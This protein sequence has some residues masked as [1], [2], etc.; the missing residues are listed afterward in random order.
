MTEAATSNTE[1]ELETY[2][3]QQKTHPNT[4]STTSDSALREDELDAEN[5][6]LRQSGTGFIGC[7][8]RIPLPIKLIILVALST[9]GVILLT[10]GL[11][12]IEGDILT[13]AT[14]TNTYI[15]NILPLDSF[16]KCIRAE[17]EASTIYIS[18]DRRTADL[19]RVLENQKCADSLAPTVRALYPTYLDSAGSYRNEAQAFIDSIEKF[20][21]TLKYARSI[22]L[23]STD[24]E[25]DLLFVRDF[26]TNYIDAVLLVS[27]YYLSALKNNTGGSL[28]L[29]LFRV[30]G[31]IARLRGAG[32]VLLID[33]YSERINTRFYAS[34]Q[35]YFKAETN[36]VTACSHTLNAAYKNALDIPEKTRVLAWA[37]LIN[38]NFTYVKNTTTPEDWHGNATAWITALTNFEKRI[39][40]EIIEQ[41]QKAVRASIAVICVVIL[42]PIGA[43]LAS[44]VFGFLF[45]RTITGPWRR[46]NRLQQE[47]IT[48]FVPASFLSA[49]KCSS[50][51]EAELGKHVQKET[52]LLNTELANLWCNAQSLSSQEKINILNSFFKVS[53]IITFL[54][55]FKVMG[56]LVRKHGGFIDRYTSNGFIALFSKRKAGVSAA[57]EM[58]MAMDR[59]NSSEKPAS[60]PEL[61]ICS[62]VHNTDVIIG[63][64]G[65]NGRISGITLTDGTELV[66]QAMRLGNLMGCRI[67]VTGTVMKAL[68]RGMDYRLLGRVTGSDNSKT[69]VYD[70]LGGNDHIKSNTKGIFSQAVALLGEKN[71]VEASHL[72]NQISAYPENA[73]N[74]Y[75]DACNHAL[76][77]SRVL[78]SSW[79][80]HDTLIAPKT[81]YAFEKFCNLERSHENVVLWRRIQEFFTL[82][83]KE[84]KQEGHELFKELGCININDKMKERIEQALLEEEEVDMNLFIELQHELETI[85]KDTHARFK[86]SSF[87]LNVLCETIFE[88]T[89]N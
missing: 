72:F 69:D 14:T 81:S 18:Y 8:E 41:S 52:L 1:Q 83:S 48:K 47:T 76:H 15:Q 68:K 13:T 60:L 50:I 11:V 67:V 38:D 30:T 19:P 3:V 85:M 24:A 86:N 70:L 6:L 49:L 36:F 40:D 82:D 46:L 32:D 37:N 53:L 66:R 78:S 80:I 64:V 9:V 56:P 39:L 2:N 20:Y 87:F 21:D 29:S 55:K 22:V 74:K 28:Y 43:L 63:V 17:R 35:R 33:G 75:A 10:I 51:A 25:K 61:T 58:Q 4:L 89:V 34:V 12:V 71:V 59:F 79:S 16:A 26:Y 31:A 84:R 62:A 44:V 45:A 77:L 54:T 23:S 88:C 65:D 7:M 73:I 57:I 27:N 42:I 5:N